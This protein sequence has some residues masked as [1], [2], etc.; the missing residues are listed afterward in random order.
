MTKILI[1]ISFKPESSLAESICLQT[2]H[3]QHTFCGSIIN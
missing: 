2:T 1:L 3:L